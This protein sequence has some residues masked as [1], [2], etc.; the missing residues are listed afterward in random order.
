[1]FSFLPVLI[2][3]LYGYLKTGTFTLYIDIPKIFYIS[4][5]LE[6]M[7]VDFLTGMKKYISYF[8]QHPFS[9]LYDR[10]QSLWDLW[11]FL[12][13]SNEGLREGIFFRLLIALRFPLLLFAIFGFLKSGKDFLSVYLIIPAFVITCIHAL[14]I[15][16]VNENYITSPRYIFPAEPFL[17]ILAVIGVHHLFRK[18]EAEG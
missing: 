14:I 6:Q 9:F 1:M 18:K 4:L 17:I 13:A 11:G 8:F 7:P 16:S 2:F 12:P 10:I 5:G 15:T 3:L